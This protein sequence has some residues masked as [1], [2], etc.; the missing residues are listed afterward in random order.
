MNWIDGFYVG[1]YEKDG[2]ETSDIAI[3]F[4]DK[5]YPNKP[6]LIY[7]NKINKN[8]ITV[9]SEVVCRFDSQT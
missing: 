5:N 9:R 6:F 4:C 2:F 3:K 8:G 7:K 1:A